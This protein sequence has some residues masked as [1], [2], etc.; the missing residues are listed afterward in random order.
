[1]GIDWR[2]VERWTSRIPQEKRVCWWEN[3]GSCETL[4]TKF[5]T[6]YSHFVFLMEVWRQINW[7]LWPNALIFH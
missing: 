7:T 4:L 6:F 3:F 5:V 2:L 1:M